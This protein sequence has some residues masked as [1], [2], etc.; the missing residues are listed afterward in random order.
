MYEKQI[1]V[2][3]P[4][5]RE[6]E[7]YSITATDFAV[8]CGTRY[9]EFIYQE[10]SDQIFLRTQWEPMDINLNCAYLATSTIVGKKSVNE[11]NYKFR[12]KA[13]FPGNDRNLQYVDDGYLHCFVGDHAL[14]IMPKFI[15]PEAVGMSLKIEPQYQGVERGLLEIDN[16]IVTYPQSYAGSQL[17]KRLESL[18]KHGSLQRVGVVTV[19]GE[20]VQCAELASSNSANLNENVMPVECERYVYQGT[21]YVRKNFAKSKK[22]RRINH[23]GDTVM[24][25][26]QFVNGTYAKPGKPMWFK[27]EPIHAERNRDG[28]IICLNALMP[29]FME[30]EVEFQRLATQS[31][32]DNV[33]L[34]NKIENGAEVNIHAEELSGGK[35]LNQV[36]LP[37]MLRSVEQSS[38]QKQNIIK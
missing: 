30:K 9:R 3:L 36:F 33:G 10:E 27:C 22:V 29:C 31:V 13:K 24:A 11:N 35:F 23:E 21:E 20:A 7:G 38:E 6:L 32:L 4:S 15:N 19:D 14:G 28:S 5:A 17:S 34:R 25:Y 8:A 37:E 18:M 12:M 26:G 16:K 2:V 1:K